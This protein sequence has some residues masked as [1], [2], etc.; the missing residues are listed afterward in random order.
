MIKNLKFDKN[1]IK[2]TCFY[3]LFLVFSFFTYLIQ[4]NKINWTEPDKITYGDSIKLD[5]SF[6][7]Q[8]KGFW[9]NFATSNDG[10]NDV[11]YK[12]NLVLFADYYDI[13]NNWVSFDYNF[14]YEYEN[15]NPLKTDFNIF[16]ED[17]DMFDYF[18]IETAIKNAIDYKVNTEHDV[19]YYMYKNI[20]YP[21]QRVYC[22]ITI[23]NFSDV[24]DDNYGEYY[25]FDTSLSISSITPIYNSNLNI[26][27]F[28]P[29]M[30][31]FQLNTNVLV[32]F[33]SSTSVL[34]DNCVLL[35]FYVPILDLSNDVYI[36]EY[37]FKNYNQESNLLQMIGSLQNDVNY[38]Q[39][40]YNNLKAQFQELNREYL[41]LNAQNTNNLR[42]INSLQDQITNLS[43]QIDSLNNII[44]QKN[45]QIEFLTNQLNNARN[46]EWNFNKLMFTIAS[47]PFESFKTF[48]NVEFWGINLSDLFLGIVF[49]GLIFFLFR[50]FIGSFFSI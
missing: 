26:S 10:V 29:N 2:F 9:Y 34:F 6:N 24:N 43:S 20:D 50:R 7:T 47:T 21:F 8:G 25:F 11:K 14:P 30:P 44:S 17:Y 33:T 5:G 48:Y 13:N 31:N 22:R 4:H 36:Y 42:L 28:I 37:T 41:L 15:T 46:A 35:D 27:Y 3:L 12:Y 40:M 1:K 39:T 49:S 19:D 16:N 18:K 23:P 32:D 38:Y 45:S